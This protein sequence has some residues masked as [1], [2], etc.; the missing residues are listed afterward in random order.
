MFH[1]LGK[2][3]YLHLKE[4]ITP[5]ST[6]LEGLKFIRVITLKFTELANLLSKATVVGRCYL[7]AYLTLQ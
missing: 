6:P 5:L 4:V 3:K 2:V 1:Y 7:T